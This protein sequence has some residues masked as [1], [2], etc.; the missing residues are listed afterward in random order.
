METEYSYSSQEC[1]QL[2]EGRKSRKEKGR[3]KERKKESL[4]CNY[5]A[6]YVEETFPGFHAHILYKNLKE[7]I[8]KF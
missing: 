4:T 3:E 6:A 7:H 8:P 5:R 1:L 2:Q